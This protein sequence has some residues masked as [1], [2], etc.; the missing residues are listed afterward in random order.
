MEFEDNL[1]TKFGHFN[2]HPEMEGGDAEKCPHLQFLKKN[3]TSTQSHS[4]PDKN[5]QKKKNEQD[6][7]KKVESDVSSDE[8]QPRG[9]CPV[10]G[11]GKD[12]DPRLEI[13]SPGF[14]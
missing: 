2:G 5:S 13:L 12:K 11:A 10:M 7:G 6:E 1:E 3:P 4:A 14:K 8:E 9:G